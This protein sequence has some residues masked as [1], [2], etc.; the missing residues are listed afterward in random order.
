M[1]PYQPAKPVTGPSYSKGFKLFATLLTVMLLA[2][3][4]SIAWRFPLPSFGIGVKALLLGAVAMLGVS[5]Y[6]FLRAAT[7]IDEHGIRQTWVYDKQVR[8]SEVRGA[9]MIGIPY[10]SWLFPPRMVVRTG[11]AFTTFNGGSREV[12]IEFA[13]ISLAYQMKR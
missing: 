3:A 10:M 7:T 8:W 5:Y 6:W 11:N 13:R 2:Y 12:L 4:A 1:T 9:K